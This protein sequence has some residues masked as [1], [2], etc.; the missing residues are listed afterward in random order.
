MKP[1][2]PLALL[3]LLPAMNTLAEPNQEPARPKRSESFL[4]IH[5]DFHAGEKDK[6]IGLKTTPAM[7]EAIIDQV[8][9]DYLQIDCKGHN[10]YSSYPTQ[11]GNAAPGVEA[12]ALKVW[13]EVT[14]RRGVSLV[15]H[16]SG[17][18]DQKAV[19]DHPDWAAYTAEGQPTKRATSLFGPYADRLLIPQLR[20]L[21][22]TYGVDGAW[23]DGEC[24]GV[25]E[26][27][28][29][30]ALEA[31]SKA[32]GIATAPHGPSEPGWNAF[33][34]FQRE[35]FRNYLRHYIGEVKKTNPGFQIASNWAFTDFMPEPVS[36]PVDFLSGDLACCDG[37]NAARVSGRYLASQG[38]PWDLMA[39]S[40]AHPND[41]PEKSVM[42]TA[43]QIEREAAVVMAQGGGFSV[44]F[45]Q[46]RDG[47][48]NTKWLPMM[49]EVAQF[50]R[51][52]Q[53]VCHHAAP[54]PQVALLLST[55]AYYRSI[56]H[57][58][59]SDG[60][61]YRGTLQALLGQHYSV[62][63]LS[64]HRLTGRMGQYP[65]IVIPA[66]DYLDPAFKTELLAYVR[67]GGHLLLA[68]PKS[69]GLFKTELTAPQVTLGKGI[70]AA[71]DVADAAGFAAKTREL[72]PHPMV[73]V[74]GSPEVDVSINQIGGKLAINLVNVSGPHATEMTI[75]KI[76]PVGPV[77]LTI[78]QPSKPAKVTLQPEGTALPFTYKK[79]ELHVTVPQV[80]IH[81][82]V[83]VEKK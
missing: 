36:A 17:V 83:T 70:L 62:E 15:M 37:V 65:L 25:A 26:D 27:Y 78:R 11:A 50:C 80:P 4:G 54:V 58:F 20:E 1:F 7:I 63:L 39:W 59:A 67:D 29:A 16:Y 35:A 10:G 60:H 30:P 76:D 38:V 43:V 31:F 74:E 66:W 69:A 44:Y 6:G 12:D 8:H 46:N 72:F 24:W 79:G 81:S 61:V 45:V 68:S 51:A 41:H 73:E 32:T 48:I 23:V 40:F 47:S 2:F 18:L 71:C 14:A 75:S 53:A 3:S 19:Q 55:P 34:D 82:I 42:K 21:A 22:G 28:S 64:E 9:P 52:R 56:R 49:A 33:L 57:P 13:R 77:N 5:Y